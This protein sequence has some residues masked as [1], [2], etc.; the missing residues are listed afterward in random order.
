METKFGPRAPSPGPASGKLWFVESQDGRELAVFLEEEKA[1]E[2]ARDFR[3]SI[4]VQRENIVALGG[5]HLQ[6]GEVGF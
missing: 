2:Y 3:G 6:K 5:G 1:R 4:V